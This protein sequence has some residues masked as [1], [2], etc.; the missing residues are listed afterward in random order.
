MHLNAALLLIASIGAVVSPV[1]LCAV[2][3]FLNGWALTRF[4]LALKT[5]LASLHPGR[6]GTTLALVTTL[7]FA[8]FGLPLIAGALADRYSLTAGFAF[9]PAVAAVLV[10]VVAAGGGLHRARPFGQL[11]TSERPKPSKRFTARDRLDG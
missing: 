2:F 7:E 8:G 6:L 10:V 9:Y 11:G 5:H 3:V 4:T 1:A